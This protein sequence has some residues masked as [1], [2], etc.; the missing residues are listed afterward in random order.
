[1][2][3]RNWLIFDSFFIHNAIFGM[4]ARWNYVEGWHGKVR[5]TGL[6]GRANAKYP[7]P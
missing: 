2:L 1:M 4:K 6:E 5:V 3:Y 7:R